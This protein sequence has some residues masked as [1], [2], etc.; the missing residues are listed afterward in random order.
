MNYDYMLAKEYASEEFEP[1]DERYWIVVGAY[2]KGFESGAKGL[3]KVIDGDRI[4]RV[5]FF[6]SSETRTFELAH[7]I[8]VDRHVFLYQLRKITGLKNIA[9]YE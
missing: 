9:I 7:P 6:F 1:S 2:L 4:T 8:M 3:L 5:V